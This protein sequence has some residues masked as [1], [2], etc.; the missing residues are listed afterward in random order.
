MTQF[1]VP[2]SY[3]EPPFNLL[4][5]EE[6]DGLQGDTEKH[7]LNDHVYRVDGSD[8]L[9]S[10]CMRELLVQHFQNA[11]PHDLDEY[12]FEVTA[13]ERCDNG[14]GMYRC[15]CPEDDR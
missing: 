5:D 11:M 9:C 4:I 14:C 8:L 13:V 12:P 7:D 3:Y 15:Q 6:C 10:G 1:H 2:A